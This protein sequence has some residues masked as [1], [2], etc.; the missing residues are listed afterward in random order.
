[1]SFQI[2]TPVP[3]VT[4]LVFNTMKELTTSMFRIEEFYESPHAVIKGQL[5][6]VDDF[7]NTYADD[8]GDIAYFRWWDGFNVPREAVDAFEQLFR[9]HGLTR[10]E[11]AVLA[12]VQ[13]QGAQYL[14]ATC[15]DSDASTVDHEIAHARWS[16]DVAYRARC[17]EA[18][19]ALKDKTR[20]L[21]VHALLKADYPDD[22]AI[23]EDEIHAYLLTDT[24]KCLRKLLKAA[25]A[26]QRRNYLAVRKLLK[27][28]A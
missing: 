5:F 13:Q 19:A 26:G 18:M 6:S 9:P 24:K 8:D 28:V 4:H 12:V 21:I 16:V 25:D 3:G 17:R 2:C 15:E 10:R 11:E 14:I 23:L 1:M 20:R 7:I 27:K 22:E